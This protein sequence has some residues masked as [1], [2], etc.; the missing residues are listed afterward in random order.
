VHKV[1]PIGDGVRMRR[2]VL[3]EIIESMQVTLP[4]RLR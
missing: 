3:E 1:R 2:A 4:E